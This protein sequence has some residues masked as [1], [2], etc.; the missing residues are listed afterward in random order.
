LEQR[1]SFFERVAKLRKQQ[2]F[3]EEI[4]WNYLRAN[5]SVINS[6]D[7]IPLYLHSGFLLP[8]A[9]KVDGP[10]H[11]IEEVKQNDATRQKQLEQEGLTF[12]RFSNEEIR[13]KLTLKKR[14]K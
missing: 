12:L 6:E 3:A 5:H 13:L 2:S 7:N 4:L 10:I 1:S 14:P 11:E 8:L 9:I